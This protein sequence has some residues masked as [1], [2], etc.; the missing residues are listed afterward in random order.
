MDFLIIYFIYGLLGL[1]Q[2]NSLLPFLCAIVIDALSR[3]ISKTVDGHYMS[4]FTMG[5]QNK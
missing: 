1:W 5:G 4:R 3:L 2:G